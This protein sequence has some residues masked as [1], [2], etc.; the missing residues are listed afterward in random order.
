MVRVYAYF[1]GTRRGGE[2]VASGYA[3]LACGVLAGILRF[4]SRPGEQTIK[5]AGEGRCE[6][7]GTLGIRTPGKASLCNQ[8]ERGGSGGFSPSARSMRWCPW[9]E[10][11]AF[12]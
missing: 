12:A 11:F 7:M 6:G 1:L 8:G 9:T 2:A 4:S 10:L 3:P 5:R